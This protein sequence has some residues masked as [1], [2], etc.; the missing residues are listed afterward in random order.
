M[1][2]LQFPPSC[3]HE[4]DMLLFSLRLLILPS[5]LG[6]KF[7]SFPHGTLQMRPFYSPHLGFSRNPYKN[8]G[9]KGCVSKN[10]SPP[11]KPNIYLAKC[12]LSFQRV[13]NS[14]FISSTKRSFKM[15]H[16][17]NFVTCF[18]IVYLLISV[19]CD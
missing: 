7:A 8:I 10:Q 5:A 14:I 6:T 16:S 3:P 13:R 2:F 15:V 18:K 11:H 19:F 12:V 1:M 4:R 17:N 9:K